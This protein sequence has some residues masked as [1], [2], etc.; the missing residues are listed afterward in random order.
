MRWRSEVAGEKNRTRR[1][2]Q[3]GGCGV[4]WVVGITTSTKETQRILRSTLSDKLEPQDHRGE[5][6]DALSQPFRTSRLLQ[7]KRNPITKPRTHKRLDAWLP[8]D[9]SVWGI[10]ACSLL[11]G[12]G[13]LIVRSSA[14]TDRA[15]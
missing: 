7:R 10:I 1:R 14:A 15:Y 2:N 9:R 3:P 12:P 6:Q 5:V 13:T 4:G 8:S 11:C